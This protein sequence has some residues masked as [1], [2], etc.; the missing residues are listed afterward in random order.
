MKNNRRSLVNKHTS[1]AQASPTSYPVF[2]SESPKVHSRTTAIL[3][4]SV[5]HWI[6]SAWWGRHVQ[7]WTRIWIRFR[8]QKYILLFGLHFDM[9][10][11]IACFIN[12]Y[13]HVW[14]ISLQVYTCLYM[15]ICTF[16]AAAASVA[17]GPGSAKT[18]S[19]RR[20]YLCVATGSDSG[21]AL[22]VDPILALRCYWVLI[23]LCLATGS[24]SG[25]VLLSGPKEMGFG[26]LKEDLGRFAIEL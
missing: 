1:T 14:S 7:T 2:S 16:A 5:A 10:V 17:L 12:V 3:F 13:I 23:W 11:G 8:S 21:F 22:L 20:V 19:S 25:S 26:W 4:T 24:Q 18:L 15:Q 6:P 9:F